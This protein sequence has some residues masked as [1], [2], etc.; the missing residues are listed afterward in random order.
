MK[1]SQIFNL[2][3][4][5]RTAI[6]LGESHFREFKSV[7]HGPPNKKVTREVK[8][9]CKD[10]GE[11]LVAF[12]NAD[13]GE[14]LIGVEDAGNITG[15]DSIPPQHIELLNKAPISQ[16]HQK[17]PLPPVKMASLI[18][19]GK[20][21][22]YFSVQ[23]S[24]SHV[25]LTSDGRC[26]Q[27]RDLETIPIPPEEIIFD[28]KERESREYDR[29]FLD[30]A[31]GSDLNA[32]LLRTVAD[33]LSPGM[34]IEKCLQYLD[35]A[36][37]VGPGVRLR[38]GAL[39]LFAKEPSRWHPR[40]QI[41]II[42]VAGIELGSGA[43][44][45]VKSDQTVTGNI[46]E[47]IERGWDS[48]RPQLVQT[49]LG[50]GARFESIVMYPELA[51]REALVNAIAHRD[52]SEEG[53]GIEIFVFDD[54][55][56]VRNPGSLLSSVSM[57][58]LLKLKGVHQSR[59]AIT[60]RVLRELGYMRELGEGLRRM[61][62]LMR[63]NELTPPELSSTAN[64]FSV[65]LRHN[66][67]YNQPQLLWLQQ[68][69]H[70][71]LSREQKAIVVLGMGGAIIAPQDIWDNL[72]IVDTEH[73]RQLVRSL[74][75]LGILTSEIPKKV[76]Q[77]RA[78]NKRVSVRKIPRFRI[79]VPKPEVRLPASMPSQSSV[80]KDNDVADDSPDPAARLWIS[81]LDFQV[82]ERE[83]VELVSE[84][85]S[86]ENIYMPKTAFGKSKGYAFIELSNPTI[87]AEVMQKLDGKVLNGRRI[88]A[89]KALPRRVG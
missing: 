49:R 42:K 68:F 52:Y 26:V 61:F 21:I 48:L 76:A 38:R 36:E 50:T 84:Y 82:D 32:D 8:S 6:S 79:S 78:R 34:S 27:R 57:S 39:L 35:L 85:A 58:D 75:E 33:Q 7:L 89:R 16:V 64:S 63:A 77:S 11:A 14:L 4:R 55:M 86:V 18:L 20:R 67:I 30:N 66:T 83:I 40:L 19:D 43:Q 73:Y 28:R 88:V 13:G 24:T 17:T 47:L 25:H 51:C 37:Y 72:G 29:E 3:E 69:D 71:S 2:E 31:T 23:K 41:R 1:E 87:A 5:A 80:E 46:L 9:V 60:S 59:N 15:I 22:L 54:R 53:R 10:I 44:Y 45:N 81:N 12:A 62:E 65:T 74:Q 70:F 56:E